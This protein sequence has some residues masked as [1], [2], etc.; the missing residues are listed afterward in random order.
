MST[1]VLHIL[2]GDLFAGAETQALIQLKALSSSL[3]IRCL[4]FNSGRLEEELKS[5]SIQVDICD[6]SLGLKHLCKTSRLAASNFSPSIIV[7]HG[8]KEALVACYLSLKLGI[9]L[10][11]T[12]HGLG[13]K[14]SGLKR[15]KNYFNNLLHRLIARFFAKRIITVSDTLKKELGF[16]NLSKAKTIYNCSPII[17]QNVDKAFEHLI[18]GRLVPIKGI[19]V[20]IKAFHKANS[21]HL[22]I[23]GNGPDEV[24]LKALVNKLNLTDRVKFLGYRE[25][26]SQLIAQA[27]TLILSSLHEGVPT[28]ILEAISAKVPIISTDLPGIREI[29]EKISD[30]PVQFFPAG[31][32]Q[33]LATL[34][35]K[36]IE[37]DNINFLKSDENFSKYFS[38]EAAINSHLKVYDELS[39]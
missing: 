39:D 34:I 20:A 18:V 37:I 9:P 16:E 10:I 29:F 31:N 14:H 13:E 22:T 23:V 38:A 3:G 6:E 30:Y 25:D 19:D 7:S 28:V 11:T 5:S 24:D 27:K 35:D 36:N 33:A 17:P 2:S 12:F 4:L 32:A 21:S 26:A 1:R 8:Y 15:F